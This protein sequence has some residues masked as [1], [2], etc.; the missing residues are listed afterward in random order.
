MCLQWVES[1]PPW[2][3]HV[4]PQKL[5]PH[6]KHRPNGDAL[7]S[8]GE[9]SELLDTW[10]NLVCFSSKMNIELSQAPYPDKRKV[11]E[12]SSMYRS[13]RQLAEQ[14]DDWTPETVRGRSTAIAEWVL[15]RWP[16]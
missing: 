16:G 6:W 11:Y 15:K 4:L 1:D 13:A 14:Y 12:K 3:E 8:E 7:F 2:I 10:G 5:P 9:H